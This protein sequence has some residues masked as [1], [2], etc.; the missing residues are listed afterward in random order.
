MPNDLKALETLAKAIK[1]SGLYD[2][3]FAKL[4]LLV[5]ERTLR[6]YKKTG[7][8]PPSKL[9]LLELLAGALDAH[10]K[11]ARHFK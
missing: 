4:K 1:A 5:N 7:E 9:A 11:A 2:R 10:T 6:R 8:I 3:Q